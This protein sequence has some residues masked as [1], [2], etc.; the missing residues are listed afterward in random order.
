MEVW[1]TIKHNHIAHLIIF[2]LLPLLAIFIAIQFFGAPRTYLIW[3]V[4]LICPLSHFLMMRKHE[5]H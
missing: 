2:C 5:G 1:E 3:L 4:L